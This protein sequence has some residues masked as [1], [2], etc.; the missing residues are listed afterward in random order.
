MQYSLWHLSV[1]SFSLLF[2]IL[3]ILVTL[4]VYVHYLHG[5][6]INY[7]DKRDFDRV[8]FYFNRGYKISKYVSRKMRL[9]FL[10]LFARTHIG[11]R[12]YEHA[13]KVLMD[14]KREADKRNM[15]EILAYVYHYLG[16]IARREGDLKGSLS[17][18]FKSLEYLENAKDPVLLARVYN[19]IGIAY[20]FL[21]ELD[22]ALEYFQ[23]C[24]KIAEAQKMYVRAA[25]TYSNTAMILKEKGHFHDAMFF[26]DR[27]L[28]VSMRINDYIR[29]NAALM[30]MGN[31]HLLLGDYNKAENLYFK[32]LKIAKEIEDLEG[33][34]Y[35]LVNLVHL[36]IQ[37]KDLTAADRFADELKFY[38][39]KYNIELPYVPTAFAALAIEQKNLEK[40]DF[41]LQKASELCE[42][43]KN[44]IACTYVSFTIVDLLIERKQF[45][46]AL[47]KL[48]AMIQHFKEKEHGEFLIN[49]HFRIA[50]LFLEW[51]EQ[52]EHGSIK[53][54]QEHI[55]FAIEYAEKKNHIPLLVKSTSALAQ[56]ES[57]N[58]NF[59]TAKEMLIGIKNRIENKGFE[60]LE[61]ELALEIQIIEKQEKA[62]ALYAS[63]EY[64]CN[65]D[66]YA[67]KKL[68]LKQAK[69]YVRAARNILSF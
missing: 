13:K 54:A 49:A 63:V 43:I 44:Y 3:V 16:I 24:I 21:G 26:L 29:A 8:L 50:E 45:E 62:C 4:R 31:I 35:I 61:K 27:C 15:I 5:E 53:K 46:D 30:G 18:Y 40:A 2:T 47:H 32:A 56:I 42:K 22:N 20:Q 67:M 7:I 51:S 64:N 48:E 55:L 37:K 19:N 66:L 11:N 68:I 6:G 12:D 10:I 9:K 58:M 25:K 52:R 34:V 28:D 57:Y 65:K 14:V 60:L 41:Y 59:K 17:N 38:S 39:K 23:K 69:D 1:Y 33:I 36:Y